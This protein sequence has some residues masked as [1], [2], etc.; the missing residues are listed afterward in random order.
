MLKAATF[1]L[2]LAATGWSAPQTQAAW[3]VS[4]G[5]SD[6]ARVA[7][8]NATRIYWV[9][10]PGYGRQFCRWAPPFYFP[11]YRGDPFR[12]EFR[13]RRVRSVVR[14]SGGLRARRCLCDTR[15]VR[16]IKVRHHRPDPVYHPFYPPPAA[17][18]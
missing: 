17:D 4:L 13:S 6:F 5:A 9:C 8:H 15:I 3:G 12:S 7:R 10:K 1:V 16:R 11:V 18:H 14:S 2:V